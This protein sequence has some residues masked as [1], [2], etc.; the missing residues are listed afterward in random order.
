MLFI[1]P[2]A[3]RVVTIT[4]HASGAKLFGR[5]E[6]GDNGQF[7]RV[8]AAK[9]AANGDIAPEALLA[10]V[11][12][13]G[14][15]LTP[16]E[17]VSTIP[18]Q[19]ITAKLAQLKQK[20]LDSGL[21]FS[22]KRIDERAADG[23]GNF[24]ISELA[25]MD[26]AH[27][28]GITAPP[29]RHPPVPPSVGQPIPAASADTAGPQAFFHLASFASNQLPSNAQPLH[30]QLTRLQ[31]GIWQVA[32]RNASLLR[33]FQTLYSGAV[34]QQLDTYGAD[35]FAQLRAQAEALNS[36]FRSPLGDQLD[37][38]NPQLMGALID[39]LNQLDAQAANRPQAQPQPVAAPA[40]QQSQAMSVSPQKV[41]LAQIDIKQIAVPKLANPLQSDAMNAALNE[42]VSTAMQLCGIGAAMDADELAAHHQIA[43]RNLN[44]AAGQ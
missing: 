44:A 32:N 20:I 27:A 42:A 30:Q 14:F 39:L 24:G 6:G 26:L 28:I 41:A 16:D 13:G 40:Q 10:P 22:G 12:Q 5:I 18:P 3:Q 2:A 17:L 15:G 8:I 4:T 19:Q 35:P 9:D 36:V 34:Q 7:S 11:E 37:Q 33:S 31:A 38:M 43:E 25:Q 29:V 21:P 1:Q 23:G